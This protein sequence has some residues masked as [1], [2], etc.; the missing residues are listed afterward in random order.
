MLAINFT[1]VESAKAKSINESRQIDRN[2][3]WA[4]SLNQVKPTGL[5]ICC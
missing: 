1:Y 3:V 2:R 5:V 4:G